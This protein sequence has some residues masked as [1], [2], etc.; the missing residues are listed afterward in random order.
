MLQSFV[1]SLYR[2]DRISSGK[3][4]Q[5]LGISRLAFIHLLD[6]EGIAYL[7]YTPEELEMEGCNASQER[8]DLPSD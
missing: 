4:A 2:Q 3:A 8:L 5:L 6:S 7:D 1:L